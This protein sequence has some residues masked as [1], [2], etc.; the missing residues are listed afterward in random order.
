MK[1]EGFEHLTLAAVLD[2]L[3]SLL[4][5][6]AISEF[7]L[8]RL[9][10][11][12]GFLFPKGELTTTITQALLP[13]GQVAY[14]LAF[15]ISSLTLGAIAIVLAMKPKMGGVLSTLIFLLLALSHITVLTLTPPEIWAALMVGFNLAS[16]SIILGAIA[17]AE[18][19]GWVKLSFF[20]ALGLAYASSQYYSLYA[21]LSILTVQIPFGVEGASLAEI[22]ALT[23]AILAFFAFRPGWSRVGVVISAVVVALF[24][25]AAQSPTL[26][27]IT[28]WVISFRLYLPLFVYA[29]A[30]GLYT[31]T[32]TG[33][34]VKR[35][36]GRVLSFGLILIA[37]GGITPPLTYLTQ[38]AVVGVLLLTS[39]VESLIRR[40]PSTPPGI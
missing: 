32:I 21:A 17:L 26:P 37:L 34:F 18:K 25:V 40:P 27:L 10:I 1:I 31:Y 33:L 13:L 15:I 23:T 22:F 4:L 5:P 35:S 14:N 11:R 9:M 29:L 16:I 6:L 24:L 2:A 28:T 20:I 7:A 39:P 19:R 12:I 38:L 8:T 30:L 3:V 36:T